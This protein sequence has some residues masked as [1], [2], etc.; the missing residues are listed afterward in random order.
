[1]TGQEYTQRIV[2]EN[3]KPHVPWEERLGNTISNQAEWA[4]NNPVE[5]AK[6]VAEYGL[7]QSLE[8]GKSL[9]DNPMMSTLTTP[10]QIF[11]NIKGSIRV[12]NDLN[13]DKEEE[14]PIS[15]GFAEGGF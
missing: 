6:N 10:Y 14:S 7:T 11:K 15:V 13:E 9:L 12:I 8:A 1:M 2:E 4:R 3:N 5:A